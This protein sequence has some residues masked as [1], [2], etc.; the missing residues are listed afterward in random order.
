M[1]PSA[2]IIYYKHRD[3]IRA[4][5]GIESGHQAAHWGAV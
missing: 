5:M 4:L 2:R 1:L 3:E